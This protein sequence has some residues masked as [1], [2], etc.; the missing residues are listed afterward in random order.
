MNLET[1][2]SLGTGHLFVVR[3]ERGRTSTVR[4][5]YIFAPGTAQPAKYSLPVDENDRSYA[6]SL[7]IAAPT[8]AFLCAIPT[9]ISRFRDGVWSSLE[10]PGTPESCAATAD[11]T[12]WVV[13]NGADSHEHSLRRFST[14]GVWETVAMPPGA[15]PQKV[16]AKGAPLWVSAEPVRTQDVGHAGNRFELYSNIPVR[17]PI[18]VGERQVPVM[19]VNGITGAD[20]DTVDVPS[21]SVSPPGPGIRACSALVVYLGKTLS[22]ELGAAL[23][24]HPD[25]AGRTLLHVAGNAPGKVEWRRAAG[26]SVGSLRPSGRMAAAVAVVPATFDQGMRLVEAIASEVSGS[27]PGLLCAVP[28]VRHSEPV[29]QGAAQA[30]PPPSEKPR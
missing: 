15:S 28:N 29:P 20:V 21:V 18:E 11:G 9:G 22:P 7:A 17:E 16:W 30:V 1:S 13:A 19:D 27:A 23:A 14:S 12:L 2:A 8:L 26:R 5:V 4:R 6:F 25:L 3:T 24:K 10:L